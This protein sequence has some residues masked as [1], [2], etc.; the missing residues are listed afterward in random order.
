MVLKEK[1]ITRSNFF[2]VIFY[3]LAKSSKNLLTTGIEPVTLAL[4]APR[5]TN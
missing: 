1:N 4:L 5:S 3:G 2:E